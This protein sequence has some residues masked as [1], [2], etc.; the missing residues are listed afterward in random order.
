MENFGNVVSS[1]WTP[2]V[3]YNITNSSK[4]FVVGQVFTSKAALQ[5]VVK[6]YSIKAHQQ[7]M[8]VASSKKLLMLRC[9]KAKEC[10]C[11][12]KLRAMVVKY[13]SF[14]AIN[15]YKGPHTCDNP[16]LNRDHQQLD[17]NLVTDHIK[18]MI[19]THFTLLV[20]VIQATIME[21]FRYEVSYKKAL[22]GKHKALTIL[23]GDFHKSYA[24]LPR[25]F[26]VLEQ[27][28]PRCVVT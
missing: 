6:M 24:E 21:K 11:T 22:V 4:E 19:K 10:Q 2:W 15:K 8:V 26:M 17:F 23:F 16:C 20:V 25:F 1:D 5:D 28:N 9:K 27:V 3:N 7:Y 13:T 14:F 12:W 18:T